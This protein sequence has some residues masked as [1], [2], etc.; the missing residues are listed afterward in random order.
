MDHKPHPCKWC[1]APVHF[2]RYARGY[3]HTEPLALL[4]VSRREA[5]DVHADPP[6]YQQWLHRQTVLHPAQPG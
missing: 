1:G 3:V 5:D 6:R 2:N 4:R